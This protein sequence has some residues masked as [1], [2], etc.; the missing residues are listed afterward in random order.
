MS[1]V[2]L[3]TGAACGLTTMD[4]LSLTKLTCLEFKILCIQHV[5]F[6]A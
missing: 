5:A 2:A 4:N 1:F 3:L 6:G